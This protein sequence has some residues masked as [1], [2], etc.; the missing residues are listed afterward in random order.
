M[1]KDIARVVT[2]ETASG[3]YYLAQRYVYKKRW[4]RKGVY[5]WENFSMKKN[6]G[7]GNKYFQH[8]SVWELEDK[9]FLDRGP[10]E[11]YCE[12][13]SRVKSSGTPIKIWSIG[14]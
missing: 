1:Y 14:Q 2:H 13:W 6:D 7:F 8:L 3:T 12:Q 9:V 5:E 10:A 11:Y 4:F